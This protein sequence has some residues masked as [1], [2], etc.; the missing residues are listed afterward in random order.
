MKKNNLILE[1]S[2]LMEK[3]KSYLRSNDFKK[4]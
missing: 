1:K 3:V 2:R 4:L